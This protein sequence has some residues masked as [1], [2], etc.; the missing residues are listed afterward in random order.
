MELI[1]PLLDGLS[2]RRPDAA[3]DPAGKRPEG[4]SGAEL[5][6]WLLVAF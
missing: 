3:E 6:K 2:Q 4:W 1:A 5:A